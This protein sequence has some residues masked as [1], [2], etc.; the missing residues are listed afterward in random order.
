[1]QTML[2]VCRSDIV[3]VLVLLCNKPSIVSKWINVIRLVK[4]SVGKVALHVWVSVGVCVCSPLHLLREL[5]DNLNQMC[6]QM[7]NAKTV[8]YA[9]RRV[10]HKIRG[11]KRQ[12]GT[13]TNTHTRANDVTG[14]HVNDSWAKFYCLCISALNA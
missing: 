1:M 11:R 6:I 2:Y 4:L 7:Q 5:K 14:M 12:G 13:H 9:R 8:I 10:Q 3:Q